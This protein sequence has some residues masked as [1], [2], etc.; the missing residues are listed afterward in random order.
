MFFEPQLKV[1]R[2]D[3]LQVPVYDHKPMASVH[4]FALLMGNFESLKSSLIESDSAN[5][6]STR[7]ACRLGDYVAAAYGIF[8]LYTSSS[9]SSSS[10]L[11]RFLPAMFEF[12]LLHISVE[13]CV[14]LSLFTKL[15]E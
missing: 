13:F 6:P 15:S 5:W 12:M 1:D 4:Y 2:L 7:N 11:K 9:S 14:S 3:F 8:F 10:F